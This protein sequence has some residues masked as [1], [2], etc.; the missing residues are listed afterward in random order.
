MLLSSEDF[1]SFDICP[2]LATYSST[3]APLRVSVNWAMNTA[4][5]TALET[6]NPIAASD[7]LMELAA[8]PGLDVDGRIY[9]SVI[10][11]SKLVEL[12]ATYLLSIER[13]EIPS[14]IPTNWGEFQPSSFLIPGNCLLRFVLC[15]RWFPEREQMER[16]S[17]RTTIDTSLTN[18]PMTIIPIVI[19][20]MR[21]GRR[22]S[23]WT[24]GFEHPQSNQI[25]ILKRDG[26]QFSDNWRKVWREELSIK[27]IEWLKLMQDDGAF[28]GRVFS[29]VQPAPP[30]QPEVVDQVA[31]MAGEMGSMR[32]NRSNCYRFKPCPFLPA[33]LSGKSPA[34]LGWIEKDS[35]TK[36]DDVILTPTIV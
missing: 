30:D 27:P 31:Q 21:E 5:H 6:A 10:H 35:L 34:Q 15:D 3:Y 29:V 4:I 16:F 13:F 24:Q 33:C 26:D 36:S 28:E 2:R 7:K 25:R 14:P 8:R 11:H 1:S 22:P 12:L 19:G 20:G 17:W 9:E 32:Q 23:V 18:L